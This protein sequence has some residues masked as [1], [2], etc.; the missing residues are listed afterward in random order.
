ME[1]ECQDPDIR[2]KVDNDE[3]VEPTDFIS[4]KANGQT[5]EQRPNIQR[6]KEVLLQVSG[7]SNTDGLD[8]EV[9]Q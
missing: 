5:V 2:K 9:V 3:D 8:R 4:Y 6:G 1:P 7:H